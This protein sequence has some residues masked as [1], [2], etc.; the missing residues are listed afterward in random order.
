M[1]ELI[2]YTYQFANI[3]FSLKYNMLMIF[4]I[5]NFKFILLTHSIIALLFKINQNKKR[6]H[7]Q[8]IYL[9]WLCSHEWL[10]LYNGSWND[11]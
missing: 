4:F 8:M 1:S 9:T 5:L 6:T 7:W 11:S 10:L 2:K 3:T